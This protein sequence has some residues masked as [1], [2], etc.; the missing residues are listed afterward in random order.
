MELEWENF[1]YRGASHLGERIRR[2]MDIVAARAS[3]AFDNLRGRSYADHT[4]RSMVYIL[5]RLAME[6][7]R[8]Y[9]AYTPKAHA[10]KVVLFRARHQLHGFNG[11]RTLGWNQLLGA[12][13]VVSDVPG[14]QQNVLTKP[15]VE[16]LAK[17]L[18]SHLKRAQELRE[19]N[20]SE[21]FG[22]R[23]IRKQPEGVACP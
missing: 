5:E 7:D 14:H 23:S 15:H 20:V 2:I 3:I 13:L 12:N 1:H 8:A 21:S 4:S 17:E 6:H 18:M 22:L 9:E 10:G 16:V 11:D 19:E